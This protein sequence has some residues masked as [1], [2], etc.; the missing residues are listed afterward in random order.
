MVRHASIIAY[1]KRG[2]PVADGWSKTD[3]DDA[4]APRLRRQQKPDREAD[5]LTIVD[6]RGKTIL[7]CNDIL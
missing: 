1:A 4:V 3:K 5:D 2:A 7:S 6:K